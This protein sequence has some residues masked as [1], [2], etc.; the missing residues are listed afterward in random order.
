[1]IWEV[2]DK[3]CVFVQ[4][5]MDVCHPIPSL[6]TFSEV[7]NKKVKKKVK[8]EKWMM[9]K[10]VQRIQIFVGTQVFFCI[11]QRIVQSR[12]KRGSPVA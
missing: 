11:G 12:V 9:M 6:N 4:N 2:L 8:N 3:K 10:H 1:V 7:S 5:H